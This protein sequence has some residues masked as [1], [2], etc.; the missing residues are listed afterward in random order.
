MVDWGRL[1]SGYWGEIFSRRFES[2]PPRHL[3]KYKN[4]F[5]KGRVFVS[6]QAPIEGMVFE[7]CPPRHLHKR[8][9]AFRK[10]RVF[11]SAQVPIERMAF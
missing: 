3:H 4:A 6:A 7:S 9:S 2:C 8:K 11:V 1:L 10:R 5:R